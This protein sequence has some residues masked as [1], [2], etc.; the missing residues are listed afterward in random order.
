MNNV[1]K[2]IRY[3][4]WFIVEYV[5]KHLKLIALSFFL[6]FFALVS[7]VSLSPYLSG[8]LSQKQKIIGYVGTYTSSNLPEEITSKISNG[9]IFVNEKGEITPVIADSWSLSNDQKKY[10]FHLKKNLVWDDGKTIS[11]FEIKYKFRDVKYRPLDE[12]T[13]EFT[14]SKPLQIFPTYLKTPILKFPLIGIGGLYRVEHYKSQ[15][16]VIKELS[17]SPNKSDLPYL[18]YKFY[19]TETHMVAA[20]KRGEINEFSTT[21][22]SIAD[23]F[24]SW[25]NSK[26]SRLIDYNR[27]LVL[28]YNLDNPF[29]QP[30][31]IRQALGSSIKL[32]DFDEDGEIAL[33]PIP[34]T[35]W[36]Y[37]IDLKPSSYDPDLGEK[38]VK[39]TLSASQSAE[40]NLST[41]FDYLE[42]AEKMAEF[43]RHIGLKPNLTV[44][45][46]DRP[47]DFDLLLTFLKVPND[48]DQYFFWHQTQT[49]G[50]IGSYKNVKIDKLLED[51]RSTLSPKQRK[52]IYEE[53][54]KN[55]VDD[56]PAAFIYF[57]Y[58]YT[59]SRK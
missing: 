18:K 57:P 12:N 8:F 22:R 55:I 17:L 27:L 46:S 51:G 56:P 29:L 20:Y 21:K 3:Y 54:Q 43:L 59:I 32:T 47:G 16:G 11:A 37:N 39:K 10:L 30:K 23:Q 2:T 48:P 15:Y 1:K 45:S 6:T 58:I 13:L 4:Y 19:D 40:I 34:P 26:V 25:K 33:G 53:L 36:A 35:S 31:E 49:E 14:L 42:P 50:N 41:Y 28:F 9:L 52:K 24:S 5:K 38:I 7:F 44:I